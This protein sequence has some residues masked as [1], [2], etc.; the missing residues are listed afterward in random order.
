MTDTQISI[1]VPIYNVEPYLRQC[2]DSIK[3]QTFRDWECILVDDGSSD[4]SPAICDEYAAGDARFRVIHEANGGLSHA[5]NA[6]LRIAKGKYIGFV[7]SDD[8]IEPEM[9]DK[10]YQLINDYDAD[11]SM[12]GY[13]KEY[14]G[15]YST[16]HLIRNTEVIDGNTAMREIGYDRLPNYVW[17]KLHK[18]EI[19]SCDF[20]EGRNFEDIFVYG[21]WL[22]NVEKVVI[23]PSP[24]YHYRMR[25]GSIVHV[26][27]AKNRYDYFLSCIDR[28][29]MLESLSDTTKDENRR[30]AYINKSAV[31]AAKIIARQ[32]KNKMLRKGAIERIRTV[33]K[34]YPLPS[35]RFMKPK[36][37]WRAYFLR[38][39]PRFFI[40]LMRGVYKFDFDYKHRNS[41]LFE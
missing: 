2:L 3:S 27:P 26:N 5:R 34:E 9:F 35:I 19:I 6:A 13:R 4:S 14:I 7:D 40:F 1:I 28:M 22:K 24:L 37:W 30:S 36:T 21:Q 32:E 33:L 20:P 17:N 8:W 10:L 29:H 25:K 18:R 23:D 39:T 31:G 15:R 12:V 16:K 38:N 11:M 41:H